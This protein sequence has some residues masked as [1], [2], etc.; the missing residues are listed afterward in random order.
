MAKV[1]KFYL[2]LTLCSGMA[3]GS[4]AV[5]RIMKPEMVRHWILPYPIGLTV[6]LLLLF[7]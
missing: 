2:F 3:I 1:N 6:L 7:K 4:T 5:N